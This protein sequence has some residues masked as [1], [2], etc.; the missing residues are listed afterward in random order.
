MDALQHLPRDAVRVQ[1]VT[2]QLRDVPELVRL[3]PVYR[4]VLGRERRLERVLPP[5]VQEAEPSGDEAVVPKEG[6]LLG[7]ALDD[8][9]DKL[10]LPARGNVHFRELVSALLERRRGHDG[11]VD[12]AAEVDE[13]LLGQVLD[14]HGLFSVAAGGREL[15][16]G[17]LPL[18]FRL[19][20]GPAVRTAVRPAAGVAVLP[21]YLP[22][23]LGPLLLPL[24]VVLVV[25]EPVQV[26]L[27]LQPRVV[28]ARVERDLI[29]LLDEVKLVRVGYGRVVR[30]SPPLDLQQRLDAVLRPPPYRPLV[31]QSPHP[32]HDG[33]HAR[34]A[35]LAELPPHDAEVAHGD[36]HAVLRGDVPLQQ[37]G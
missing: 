6:P 33:V 23:D 21:E 7:A 16:V 8:H 18:V 37:H 2:E 17:H 11:E 9:V 27:H 26:V 35:D 25:P 20:V 15:L 14:D 29:L 5:L 28:E 4:G 3:E 24:V 34:R 1:Q 32:F 22:P 12:G 19:A 36:V 10:H 13:V 30:E 31:E